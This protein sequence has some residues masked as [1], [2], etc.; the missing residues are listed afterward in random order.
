MLAHI[1]RNT[2][3][4]QLTAFVSPAFFDVLPPRK[5]Y[6]RS[7]ALLSSRDAPLY[8]DAVTAR[9]ASLR[10][11][12]LAIGIQEAPSQSD[13]LGEA[14][15]ERIV[16]LYFHQLF[17]DGDTLLDVRDSALRDAGNGLTWTPSAWVAKWDPAFLSALRDVY[18]GF[19]RD[20]DATFRA[21]LSRLGIAACED[22]FREHFGSNQEA[23]QFRTKEFVDTFHKVF[24]R[25]RDQGIELH[26][27]FL[28]LGIYLACL[29]DALDARGQP[30][31]VRSCFERALAQRQPSA[32]VASR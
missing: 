21:G 8:R 18:R 31:D 28:P 32:R 12:P 23:H 17:G 20:G 4:K 5:L 15:A 2:E 6:R 7:R 24:V 11:L 30:V 13:G 25:C 22:L 10:A 26:A 16:T 3:W 9:Q 14:N 29:H 27:D 1:L 19:Y